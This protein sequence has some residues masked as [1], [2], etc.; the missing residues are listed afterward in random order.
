MEV[1]MAETREQIRTP[2]WSD[3]VMYWLEDQVA[4]VFESDIPLSGAPTS[5]TKGTIISTL[6]LNNLDQF[7]K[8]RGFKLQSFT[9]KDVPHPLDEE[10]LHPHRE[11]IENLEREIEELEGE[12]EELESLNHQ[13]TGGEGYK[14]PRQKQIEELEGRVEELEKEIEKLESASRD[15]DRPGN[16]MS[17]PSRTLNSTVG[18]YLFPLPDDQGTLVVGFFNIKTVKTVHSSQDINTINALSRSNGIQCQCESDSNTRKIVSLINSSLEKLRQDAKVPIVAAAPNWLGGANCYSHGCPVFPPFPVPTKDT[19]GTSPGRWPIQIP[20]ISSDT[21]PIREMKGAGVTVFVLDSM[22]D[23][24]H[25]PDLIKEAAQGVGKR[26]E[27]LNEIADQLDRSEQPFIKFHYQDMPDLLKENALDQI[28][29]GR[30]IK[31]HLYGFHMPDHGLFVTGIIRD[32]ACD[33]DIEYV[34]VLNDFGTC[35]VSVVIKALEDIQNRMLPIDPNTGKQGNLYNKPVVINLSL[36]VTP[37]EEDL[38]RV[39][40]GVEAS[41]SMQGMQKNAQTKYDTQQLRSHLHKVIQSLTASGAVI[42]ASAG[43]DSNSPDMP[44]RIGPRFP[45]AFQEVIA[46]GA[47]DG[48]G[49]AARYSN[50]PQLSPD[51]NGIATYGGSIPTLEAIKTDTGIDAMR[52]VFSDKLYP[53]PLAE[54]PP[55]PDYDPHNPNAWAYWSG[56]SF[57]TP[58]ISAVAARVLQ[59]KAS[60]WPSHVRVRRVHKAMLTPKG[61]QKLLTGKNPLPKQAEFGVGLLMAYQCEAKKTVAETP[62]HE[63]DLVHAD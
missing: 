53:A 8:V 37:S 60:K 31:G 24:K 18:K 10:E 5:P 40:F 54:N 32:L 19:C 63:H 62:E 21:S 14:S 30:D 59:L 9:S 33:A 15:P 3:E 25:D 39:W 41:P 4:I 51:H 55:K 50:F 6:N 43:N 13:R 2:W 48:N 57:A 26:N 56:T 46:V 47:V 58:I 49:K 38:L 17:R 12:I 34:R 27:L 1:K 23:I 42:V 28:V 11:E 22:P 29:T 7:L 36:V 45:A 35:S 52:G 16:G 61:Q 20:A 44:G